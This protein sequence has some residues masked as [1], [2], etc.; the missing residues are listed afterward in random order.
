MLIVGTTYTGLLTCK[1]ARIANP[2]NTRTAAIPMIINVSFDNLASIYPDIDLPRVFSVFFHILLSLANS[3]VTL[4]SVP[5]LLSLAV[6]LATSKSMINFLGEGG[7][8]PALIPHS[9]QHLGP[10]CNI[11][12]AAFNSTFLALALLVSCQTLQ[13]RVCGS[14]G[15]SNI[16]N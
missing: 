9:R 15:R 13:V 12:P 5:L 2:P 1:A 4:T 10:T 16:F 8:T 7:H 14:S 6:T 3:I 11:S